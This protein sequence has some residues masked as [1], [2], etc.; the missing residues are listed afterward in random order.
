M[1]GLDGICQKGGQYCKSRV[2]S[3]A[4]ALNS[5]VTCS[6]YKSGC[7]TTGKGC[8]D[9]LGACSTY[10]GNTTTCL[11]YVGVDGNCKGVSIDTDRSCIA[12]ECTDA[13]ERVTT[14]KECMLYQSWCRTTGKGCV[15]TLP[16]CAT[17]GSSCNA[18]TG[19]EGKCKLDA[20]GKCQVSVCEDGK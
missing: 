8:I 12:M 13:P 16:S 4:P 3:E 11:G 7:L 17:Y 1:I 15:R 9:Q 20:D 19:I 14:D 2:C 5:N 6:L 10:L 18:M